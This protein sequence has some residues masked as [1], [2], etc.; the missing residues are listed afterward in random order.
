[1]KR[2][3]IPA[4]MEANLFLRSERF[5]FSNRDGIL[6][7]SRQPAMANLGRVSGLKLGHGYMLHA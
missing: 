7:L 2:T 4:V 5:R 1:M 6:T 3:R